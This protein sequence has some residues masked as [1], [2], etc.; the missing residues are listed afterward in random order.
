MLF[1]FLFPLLAT[2]TFLTNAAYTPVKRAS[3]TVYSSCARPKT[4]ALTFDDGPYLYLQD[5][6]DRLTAAG[7]K[8][9]FFFN[10]NNF[11]CIYNTDAA[12]RVKY[13]FNAGHMIGSHTWSHADLTTLSTAQLQDSMFRMEEAFSRLIGVKPAFMRPPYGSLNDNVRNVAFNRNQS[14]ALWDLDTGDASGASVSSSKSVYTNAVNQNLNNMLVLNHET[15]Q[16]T[17]DQVLPFAIDLLQSH[18]YSLVTLAECLGVEPYAAIGVPQTG[19]FSCDGSPG[20]GQA[21]SGGQCQT[22]VPFLQ[23]G[24]TTPNQVIHPG[25]SN[26]KCLTAPTNANNAAVVIQDCDGSASQSWTRSGSTLTIYGNKCLDVTGG[27]TADGVKMQIYTCNTGNANQ[28]FTTGGNTIA[29]TGKGKCLDLTSGVLTNGNVMQMWTC[30]GGPNQVW[31]FA[32]GGSTQ[33]PPTGNTIRPGAS[34]SFCLTAASNTNSAAVQIQPCSSGSSS[35][36]WTN[37]GGTLQIFGNKCLD[38]TAG[39][40]ANG[41]K[42]QIYTCNAGNANQQFTITGDKRITWTGKGKCLDLTDGLLNSGNVVQMWQ[43][44]AGNNN[45]VWNFV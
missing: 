41:V 1:S 22:G 26:S 43:C 35:Q 13:A 15:L 4:V 19:T 16:T 5:I 3:P 40:T 44:S 32:N 9:T 7:A 6:S 33:P 45:Q 21:C 12:S 39:S 20:P 14:V 11:D 31:N 36:S 2:S 38:V 29:W 30:T 17:A 24:E 37:I 42:M 10:G 8:G 34:G 28:Q 25:A 23:T 27:S 18:G